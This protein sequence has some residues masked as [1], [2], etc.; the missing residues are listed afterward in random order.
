MPEPVHSCCHWVLVAAHLAERQARAGRSTGVYVRG[1]VAA[2]VP[3]QAQ[4]HRC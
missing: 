2:L 3:A 1:A 4:A